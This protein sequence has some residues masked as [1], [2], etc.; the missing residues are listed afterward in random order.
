MNSPVLL[1]IEYEF[2][3]NLLFLE[4]MLIIKINQI[5]ILLFFYLLLVFKSV[6][7]TCLLCILID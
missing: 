4:T 2:D 3:G 1:A 7:F 5:I 6:K